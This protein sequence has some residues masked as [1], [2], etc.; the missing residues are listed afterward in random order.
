MLASAAIALTRLELDDV[1]EQPLWQTTQLLSYLW[2]AQI[3]ACV[4]ANLIW[5]AT[6]PL[7]AISVAAGAASVAVDQSITRINFVGWDDGTAVR[8]IGFH[9][10][11]DTAGSSWRQATGIPSAVIAEPNVL[12]P[13]PRPAAAGTLRLEVYRMPL[14]ASLSMQ[15]V[16]EVPDRAAYLLREWVK[17]RA[18]SIRDADAQDRSRAAEALQ[19]FEQ[20]FGPRPNV[21]AQ[22]ERLQRRAPTIRPRG[23]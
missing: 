13:Y 7:C 10:E 16:L 6:S 3:E 15:S 5:D 19:L 17:Y 21:A 14:A 8:E 23:F 18:Y 4:R 22:S 9:D 1:S 2:E 12:R 11:R 20:Q